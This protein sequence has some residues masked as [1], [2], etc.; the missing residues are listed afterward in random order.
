MYLIIHGT[1]ACTRMAIGL[2]HVANIGLE[3]LAT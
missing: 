3:Y 1:V 2:M